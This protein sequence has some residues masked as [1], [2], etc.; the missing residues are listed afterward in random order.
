MNNELTGKIAL[1]TGAHRGIG[2]AIA[3]ELAQMGATIVAAEIDQIAVDKFNAAFKELGLQGQGFVMDVSNP[4]SIKTAMEQIVATFGAPNILVNNAG[5][6]RDNLM[7]RMSEDDWN[8]VMN[9]NLNSVFY[10]TKACLRDM[11]KAR[12]G[13][14]VSIASVV[15]VTGNP[16]QANY[17]ASKAGIIAFGKSVAAEVASR[18]ITVNAVAPGYIETDMTKKLTDEQRAAYAENVPMRRPGQPSDIAKAVAFLVSENASYITG[19]TLHVN[20]GMFMA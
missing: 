12:Y 11:I 16:G 10:L 1:V 8:A 15:G 17:S 4:T 19:Q 2:L 9:V 20:G 7:L 18:N 14:I 5:I 13:R 6:A 3:T